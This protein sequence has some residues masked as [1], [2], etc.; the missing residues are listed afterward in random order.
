MLGAILKFFLLGILAI[1]V[2]GVGLG[3]VSM[4]FGLAVGLAVLAVK[5]GVIGLIGYGAYKVFR[6]VTGREKPREISAADRKWL[7]S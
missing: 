3:L 2:V 5:V 6:A 7:E 4:V 1:I